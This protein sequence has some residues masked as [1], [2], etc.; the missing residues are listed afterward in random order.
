[1]QIRFDDS[2]LKTLSSVLGFNAVEV[3]EIEGSLRIICDEGHRAEASIDID[4][5]M[6]R[7]KIKIYWIDSIYLDE[8]KEV[9]MNF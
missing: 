3:Y 4:F 6:R 8:E 2:M 9:L 5:F 7:I 1:M